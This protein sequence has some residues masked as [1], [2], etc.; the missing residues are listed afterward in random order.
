MPSSRT[1]RSS[2]AGEVHHGPAR[3]AR[4][5]YH[6]CT[7][8]V[9]GYGLVQRGRRRIETTLPVTGIT[10]VVIAATLVATGLTK[11][12]TTVPAMR[13]VAFSAVLRRVL[14][15]E[16]TDSRR[17]L[18]YARAAFV[19]IGALEVLLG[20]WLLAA[21]ASRIA[22]LAVAGFMACGLT[23]LV[24]ARK[25]APAMSCGCSRDHQ[26]AGPRSMVRAGGFL[27]AALL[28]A[29][30]PAGSPAGAAAL[31]LA[32][33]G[34]LL[35]MPSRSLQA[36]GTWVFASAL[37][38]RCRNLLLRSDAWAAACARADR[39]GLRRGPHEEWRVG[40]TLYVAV[41][42]EAQPGSEPRDG[43]ITL[44]G[45]I[46]VAMQAYGA[47]RVV[48]VVETE[49]G[50]FVRQAWTSASDASRRHPATSQPPHRSR[51]PARARPSHPTEA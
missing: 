2:A 49:T 26:P 38:G 5:C 20:L 42:L 15:A 14:R 27:L 48:E 22:A 32:A 6:R 39:A 1:P 24:A 13:T 47:A 18:V 16:P 19:G 51:L 44:V 21:V 50:A 9:R 45:T 12:R 36:V 28:L 7:L 46:R 23:Y 41:A 3:A 30:M 25:A 8:A 11:S 29:L 37:H 33:V 31:V 35:F 4:A 40:R 43:R 17:A 10:R 34:V